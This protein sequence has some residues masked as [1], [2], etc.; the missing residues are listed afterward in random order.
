MDHSSRFTGHF[1]KTGNN[2]A[3]GLVKKNRSSLGA[4]GRRYR[5]NKTLSLETKFT[6]SED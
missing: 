1:A 4:G 3:G 5:T 2:V 6:R